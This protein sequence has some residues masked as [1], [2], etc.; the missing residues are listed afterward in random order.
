M[1]RASRQM[2]SSVT[3]DNADRRSY[4][5]SGYHSHTRN[6]NETVLVSVEVRLH[7]GFQLR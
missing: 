1:L 6:Y 3:I 4:A 7:T 2:M 5:L